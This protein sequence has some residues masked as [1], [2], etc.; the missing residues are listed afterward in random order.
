MKYFPTFLL[1]KDLRKY[2]DNSLALEIGVV[3]YLDELEDGVEIEW[4]FAHEYAHT[5]NS[6]GV[7]KHSIYYTLQK[8]PK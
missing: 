2:G 6:I 3:E 7:I 4:L 8:T 1:L 5:L